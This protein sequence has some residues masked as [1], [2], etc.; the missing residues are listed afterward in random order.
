MNKIFTS[1]FPTSLLI[2]FGI[3]TLLAIAVLTTSIL[4][5]CELYPNP[6]I[7]TTVHSLPGAARLQIDK[8]IL[9]DQ[10]FKRFSEC[11]KDANKTTAAVCRAE[12][13]NSRPNH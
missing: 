6:P 10:A 9:F 2:F 8:D 13:W 1:P 3:G 5:P 11:M 12:F 7:I 4:L